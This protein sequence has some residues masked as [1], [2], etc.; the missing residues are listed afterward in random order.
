MEWIRTVM[1]LLLEAI[2][3]IIEIHHAERIHMTAIELH[4]YAT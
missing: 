1:S 4:I 3:H 2:H